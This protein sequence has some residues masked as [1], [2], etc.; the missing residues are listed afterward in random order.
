MM[1]INSLFKA[2]CLFSVI[3]ALNVQAQSA[4]KGCAAKK[5]SLESQIAYAKKHGNTQEITGLQTA[6]SENA[7]CTDEGLRAD[8]E[9]KIREKQE[10]VSKQQTKLN[11]AQATDNKKKIAKNLRKLQDAQLELKKAQDELNQ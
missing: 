5:A 4:P 10:K 7:H 6:L 1:K 8:R 11:E 2:V 9:A 3:L